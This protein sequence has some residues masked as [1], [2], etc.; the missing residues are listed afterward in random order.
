MR[1]T[2]SKVNIPIN[3]LKEHYDKLFNEPLKKKPPD[4]EITQNET[5]NNKINEIVN[6]TNTKVIISNEEI[7]NIILVP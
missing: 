2:E 1:K 3:I 4:E 6:D 5:I 7:I